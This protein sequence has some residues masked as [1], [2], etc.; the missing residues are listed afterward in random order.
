MLKSLE[1]KSFGVRY[2]NENFVVHEAKMRL[3]WCS[4]LNR[5]V[6]RKKKKQNSNQE[7]NQRN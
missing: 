3:L 6:F 7:N 2:V 5:L 1:I 4:M